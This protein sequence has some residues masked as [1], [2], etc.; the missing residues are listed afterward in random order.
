VKVIPIVTVASVLR[1]SVVFCR[2]IPTATGN[3]VFAF[4]FFV[5]VGVVFC[6]LD[7]FAGFAIVAVAVLAQMHHRRVAL[8]ARI[9]VGAVLAV[10]AEFAAGAQIALALFPLLLKISVIAHFDFPQY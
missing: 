10:V 3:T 4:R 1:Q 8:F 6:L 2:A 7:F 9:V 5:R